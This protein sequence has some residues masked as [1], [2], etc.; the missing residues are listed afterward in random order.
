LL[1]ILKQNGRVEQNALKVYRDLLAINDLATCLNAARSLHE[2]KSCLSLAFRHWMP[3][4]STYF[5]VPEGNT[6]RR[7][8]LSGPDSLPHDGQQPLE[9]GHA[10][11]VL[12][13]GMPVWIADTASS[14]E[15]DA[16][17][18]S[19]RS[20]VVLP[21]SAMGK[22]VAALE[23]VSR[24]PNRF[25]KADYYLVSLVST[26]VSCS[27]ENI[28]TR[29]EL[30]AA[31]E[32]LRQRDARLTEL[33][34]K[35]QQLAH[36]DDATGL[37]NKRRLIEQLEAEIARSR[38]YGDILSCLMLDIDHFK[39]IND[40]LG[41]QAGDEVLRQIGGLL[42]CSVRVTDLVARYGGEEFTILL[43]KT[44]HAGAWRAAEKLRHS[45]EAH[46]FVASQLDI[47]LTV[48]IGIAS[49]TRFDNLDPHQVLLAADTALYRAK[50]EGR[51]RTCII[52]DSDAPLD[53]VKILAGP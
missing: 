50:G 11:S 13:T 10:G 16:S 2:L 3:Q 45:V 49:Y 40:T 41:H 30:S 26:H 9:Y 7:S 28:L 6:F 36:T 24:R 48:S 14:R 42:R 43:P 5:C 44:G 18:R 53:T 4:D 31:N 1:R 33:N 34:R 46:T 23:V 37:F 29:E 21:C 22:L 8:W 38:R 39:Q 20:I 52:E 25:D 17:K 47:R 32:L 35:L 12:K 27:L 15:A 19:A 51:N